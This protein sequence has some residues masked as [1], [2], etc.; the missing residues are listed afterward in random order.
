MSEKGIKKCYQY[1]IS[2]SYLCGVKNCWYD[3]VR[4]NLK[5]NIIKYV[6]FPIFDCA[7]F[8]TDTPLSPTPEYI[9]ELVDDYFE[10]ETIALIVQ[11]PDDEDDNEEIEDYVPTYL[12]FKDLSAGD[13]FTE[14]DLIRHSLYMKLSKEITVD[15]NSY[16][17]IEFVSG[18]LTNINDFAYVKKLKTSISFDEED[19][20]E[21]KE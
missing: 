10:D 11:Y 15:N 5:V 13:I 9:T 4:E 6:E 7:C 18:V 21:I 20:T 17:A 3:D 1:N 19:F 12:R 14:N 8:Q 16:N 2:I